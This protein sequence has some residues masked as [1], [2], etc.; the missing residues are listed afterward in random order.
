MLVT[1]SKG[2]VTSQN[3]RSVAFYSQKLNPAQT[4]YT[5]TEQE[6]LAIVDNIEGLLQYPDWTEDQS[7][8]R[9]QESDMQELQHRMCHEMVP[10]S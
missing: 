7:V 3:G 2:A 6:L 10:H 9:S 8:Y 4:C 5:T 1:P